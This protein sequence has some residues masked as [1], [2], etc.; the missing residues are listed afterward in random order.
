MH[1][2]AHSSGW[3]TARW[4]NDLLTL[5]SYDDQ[6]DTMLNLTQVFTLSALGATT[7]VINALTPRGATNIRD[8]LFAARSEIESRPTRAAVHAGLLITDWI[9]NFPFG[10][11]PLEA[12]DEYAEGGI[13]LYTLAVGQPGDVDM[14][15]SLILLEGPEV[16]R[17]RLATISQA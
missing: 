13:R 5:V 16:A 1:V 17:T 3:S 8:A 9:H 14:G 4:E 12:L 7:K 11:S 6:I 15:C 2:M 10:S